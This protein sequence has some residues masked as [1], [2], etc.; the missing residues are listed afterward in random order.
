MQKKGIRSLTQTAK[1]TV[2]GRPSQEALEN[3]CKLVT[4]FCAAGKISVVR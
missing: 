3:F 2:H 1:V 4:K